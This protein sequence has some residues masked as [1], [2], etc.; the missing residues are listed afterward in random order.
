[1]TPADAGVERAWI[2]YFKS[3]KGPGGVAYDSEYQ[4]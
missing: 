3:I 1:M 2:D 4:A